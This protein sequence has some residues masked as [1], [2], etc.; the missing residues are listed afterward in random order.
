GTWAF[1]EGAFGII[2]PYK[3]SYSCDDNHLSITIAR[4]AIYAHHAPPH[5]LSE[6]EDV[7]YLDQG[8]QEFTNYIIVGPSDWESARMPHLSQQYALQPVTY[9]EGAHGGS[10]PQKYSFLPDPSNELLTAIFMDGSTLISRVYNGYGGNPSVRTE[11][12]ITLR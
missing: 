3:S 6:T 5:V 4:S 11:K 10:L 1:V 8:W 12:G 2:S 9:Q 7:R